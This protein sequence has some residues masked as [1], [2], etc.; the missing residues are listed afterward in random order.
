MDDVCG[1]GNFLFVGK[2][3]FDSFFYDFRIFFVPDGG[4]CYTGFQSGRYTDDVFEETVPAALKQ[5]GGF[6]KDPAGGLS[7][8]PGQEILPDCR[9][10]NGIDC[11]Q[12]PLVVE[13]DAGKFVL[14]YG[15]VCPID[16]FPEGLSDFPDDCRVPVDLLLCT[17]VCIEYGISKYFKNPADGTFPGTDTAGDGDKPVIQ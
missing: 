1:T 16:V 10:Y 13:N 2:L 14:V 9:M 4:S 5:D 6:Q 11:F 15:V 7:A 3:V 17:F 8:A 12:C